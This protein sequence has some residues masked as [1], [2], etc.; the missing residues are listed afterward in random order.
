[1]LYQGRWRQPALRGGKVSTDMGR[2]LEWWVSPTNPW[3]FPTENDQHLGWRLGVA[4]FKERPTWQWK[5]TIFLSRYICKGLLFHC[6]VGFLRVYLAETAKTN[7][8]KE[9][10]DRRK[11]WH[12][13]QRNQRKQ[14]A[15]EKRFEKSK[16]NHREDLLGSGC[17]IV[18]VLIW[19]EC[20]NWFGR[21]SSS[22]VS[23]VYKGHMRAQNPR[24]LLYNQCLLT[25]LTIYPADSIK[26]KPLLG[27]GFHQNFGDL[28][29]SSQDVCLIIFFCG[30]ANIQTCPI[31]RLPTSY[32][33]LKRILSTLF[34]FFESRIPLKKTISRRQPPTCWNSEWI[35]DFSAL[36]LRNLYGFEHVTGNN[37]G[38]SNQPQKTSTQS[39][40]LTL[41]N[42]ST[43]PGS[44]GIF[45]AIF[46]LLS[47]QNNLRFAGLWKL[48][49]N[50]IT[51][52]SF[53]YTKH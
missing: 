41:Q 30:L 21:C 25:S 52:S 6:H 35:F 37:K 15:N 38:N 29:K 32:R 13:P 50:R 20:L 5:I 17:Y 9:T 49:V 34:I 2:V 44:C 31:S 28:T 45:V 10:C 26:I 4:P 47:P 23:L 33:S 16:L 12:L 18:G 22:D 46:F 36:C 24:R 53:K 11:S 42:E 7:H 19:W 8:Y 39:G 43:F 1:M 48:S 3:G 40:N 14:T 51:I 27:D